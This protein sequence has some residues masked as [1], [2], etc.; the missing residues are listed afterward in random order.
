MDLLTNAPKNRFQFQYGFVFGIFN[1]AAVVTAPIF[2]KYGT[3]IGPK[4]LYCSGA[5]VLGIGG[6]LFGFLEY[7]DDTDTFIG[8]SY[9]LR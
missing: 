7:V 5:A 4:L 2:G 1:L 3:K 6:V 9:L 8:L